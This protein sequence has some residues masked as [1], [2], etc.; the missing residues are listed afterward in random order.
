MGQHF[1]IGVICL[2]VLTA[3]TIGLNIFFKDLVA[4]KVE[5]VSY[6]T[7]RNAADLMWRD[8]V[9]VRGGLWFGGGGGGLVAW[10]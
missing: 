4:V 1:N 5:Y 3:A 2:V 9:I 10:C 7:V 8:L 6:G